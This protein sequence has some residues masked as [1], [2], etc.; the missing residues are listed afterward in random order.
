MTGLKKTL[1]T[2]PTGGHPPLLLRQAEPA[3]KSLIVQSPVTELDPP[4][5]RT[6]IVKCWTHTLDKPASIVA[7]VTTLGDNP[8]L[9]GTGIAHC[10]GG[11]VGTLK[12]VRVGEQY[13]R[14][15]IGTTIVTG[16]INAVRQA[17]AQSVKLES[18]VTGTRLYTKL[19]FTPTGVVHN[20]PNGERYTEMA[21]T[22]PQPPK[23]KQ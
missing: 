4:A 15:G 22:F 9:V 7:V 5:V 21:R 14:Q 18:S 1:I 23:L 8:Q 6:N 10:K 11:T 3:D 2:S 16:L 17:K 20:L 19:G 12:N 13:Q